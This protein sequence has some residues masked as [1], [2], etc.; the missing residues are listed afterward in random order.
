MPSTTLYVSLNTRFWGLNIKE[1]MVLGEK[2]ATLA[3][4]Q[5]EES[6]TQICTGSGRVNTPWLL[7]RLPHAINKDG[8]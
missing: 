3:V 2:R 8:S 4:S 5:A 7:R 6:Q 1:A